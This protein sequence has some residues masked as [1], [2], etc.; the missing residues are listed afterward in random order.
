LSFDRTAFTVIATA[1]GGDQLDQPVRAS[2]VDNQ[3]Y[4]AARQI[5]L[6]W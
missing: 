2:T 5:M 1:D 4:D 3:R 6:T